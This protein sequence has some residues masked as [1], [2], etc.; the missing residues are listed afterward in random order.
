MTSGTAATSGTLATQAETY[1]MGP[2]KV[3]W[4]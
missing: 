2:S 3:L 1:C 4:Q